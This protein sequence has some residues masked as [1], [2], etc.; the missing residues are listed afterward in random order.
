[1]ADIKFII[2]QIFGGIAVIL[3][4][5]S[6]QQKSQRGIIVYQIAAAV[7]FTVN[8]L[9]L[10]APTGVALNLLGIG[11]CVV[12]YY[13]NKK[14]ITNIL[15]PII[16]SVIIIIAS[17]LTWE[18]LYSLCIMIGLVLLNI[19]FSFKNPQSTRKVTLV[20]SPLCMV[21]NI[22]V[23]SLGGVIFECAV[24]C[25]CIIGLIKNNEV[26]N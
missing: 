8:Y 20:K 25:S 2:A 7:A 15:W 23:M 11:N 22:A 21:Y 6:F 19:S 5:I 4:F 16:F 14:N 12:C 26:K 1:M 9:L 10:D 3:G 24:L 17:I 18:N 13:L